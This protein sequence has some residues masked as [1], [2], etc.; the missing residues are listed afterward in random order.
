MQFTVT[1]TG[2]QPGCTGALK[3]GPITFD[4][5]IYPTSQSNPPGTDVYDYRPRLNISCGSTWQI[6]LSFTVGNTSVQTG[7][8]IMVCAGTC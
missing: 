2:T 8:V 1:W 4:S 6:D 5:P 3:A 7:Y